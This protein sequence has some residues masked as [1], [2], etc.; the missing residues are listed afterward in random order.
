[1]YFYLLVFAW[2]N[3]VG[4]QEKVTVDSGLEAGVCGGEWNNKTSHCTPSLLTLFL[5]NMNGVQVEH[6][7]FELMKSRIFQNDTTKFQTSPHETG[8]NQN[9]SPPKMTF[10]LCVKVYMK[11]K[12]ISR[13]DLGPSP[14]YHIMYMQIFQTLKIKITPNP[15]HFWSQVVPIRDPKL[16]PIQKT[17]REEMRGQKWRK[18]KG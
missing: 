9:I 3:A 4:M 2:R 6:P 14:K 15:K 12:L 18:W 17:T 5:N 8:H 11:H 1:M 7:Y 13:L 10:K 16:V